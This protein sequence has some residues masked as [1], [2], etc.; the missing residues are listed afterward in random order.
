MKTLLCA[1][2]ILWASVASAEMR[3][4]AVTAYNDFGES[5][6]SGEASCDLERGQSVTLQWTASDGATGYKM[7]WG[8][9][10]RTYKPEI[11]VG[12]IQIHTFI[13]MASPTVTIICE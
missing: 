10:P 4:F 8:K 12:D 2:L 9:A 5:A 6:Y 7:Y 11:D 1:A 13:Q 3:Y